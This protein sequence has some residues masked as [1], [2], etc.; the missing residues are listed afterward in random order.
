M[1]ALSRREYLKAI[2]PRYRVA[3]RE[4]KQRILDEFCRICGYHRK[5][6]IRL[7]K[8]NHPRRRRR[9]RRPPLYGQAERDVLEVIWLTANRP[10]SRRLKAALT[11]PSG[12]PAPSSAFC[13]VHVKALQINKAWAI[14]NLVIVP[15][16]LRL[17]HFCCFGF[18]YAKLCPVMVRPTRPK[19]SQLAPMP[20]AHRNPHGYRAMRSQL[21]L[22]LVER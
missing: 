16:S 2:R 3:G 14:L 7:L 4:Y 5:H 6:A 9:P 8:E 13:P 11:M 10:C 12:E 18:P 21:A 20:S 19:V 1:E 17:F 22:A 15:F